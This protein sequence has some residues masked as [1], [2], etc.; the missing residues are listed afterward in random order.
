MTLIQIQFCAIALTATLSLPRSTVLLYGPECPEAAVSEPPP[1]ALANPFQISPEFSPA[2][3][4]SEGI[5]FPG[6]YITYDVKPILLDLIAIL[7][8]FQKPVYDSKQYP[9]S[10]PV[11]TSKVDKSADVSLLFYPEQAMTWR[12][13][14]C[15]SH[16]LRIYMDRWTNF[17][18]FDRHWMPLGKGELGIV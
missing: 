7:E 16:A 3:L 18:I 6:G 13:L 4:S 12:D 11:R 14:G 1:T 10:L 2:N 17:S 8:I 5:E 9:W 15:A